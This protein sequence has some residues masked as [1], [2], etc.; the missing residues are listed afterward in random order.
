MYLYC[1]SG[2]QCNVFEKEMAHLI[3]LTL[4]TY[5]LKCKSEATILS[6]KFLKNIYFQ[7]QRNAFII[8]LR[9]VYM[10]VYKYYTTIIIYDKTPHY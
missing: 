7:I 10:Y 5:R 1:V 9:N 3:A 8:S 2:L 4:K 6:L